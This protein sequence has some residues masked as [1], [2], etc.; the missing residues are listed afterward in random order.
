MPILDYFPQKTW[1]L[2]AKTGSLSFLL[3]HLIETVQFFMPVFRHY[4]S[5]CVIYSPMVKRF[6]WTNKE[7][8]VYR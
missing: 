1:V 4:Y 7:R 5:L 2:Y 8:H 6:E 3:S